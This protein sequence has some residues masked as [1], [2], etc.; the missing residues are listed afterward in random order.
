MNKLSLEDISLVIL[1]GGA[2]QRMY[3]QDKGLIEIGEKK[4]INHVVEK[5]RLQTEK[6]VISANRHLEQYESL[7]YPVIK[8]DQEDFQGPLAGILAAIKVVKT[9][10]LL[11]LPCDAPIVASNYHQK[12]LDTFNESKA[13]LVVASD[14]QQMQPDYALIPKGLQQDLEEYM[15]KGKRKASEWLKRHRIAL[16]DFSRQQDFFI[17]LN[18]SDE[19]KDYLGK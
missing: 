12:M 11:T 9:D 8:D 3:G 4:L 14:G 10:Y 7:G 16:A 18:T 6:I 15:L 2:G 17:N 19:L 5:A 13:D 1:A